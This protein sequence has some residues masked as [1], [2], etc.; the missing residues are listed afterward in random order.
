[1]KFLDADR[2]GYRH[3]RFELEILKHLRTAN[4]EHPGYRHI[5][6]LEDDFIHEGPNGVRQVLVFKV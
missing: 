1:M 5:G 4:P 2:Y 3:D 6:H